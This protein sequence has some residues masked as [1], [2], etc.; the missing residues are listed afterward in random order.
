[1][2][3]RRDAPFPTLM[4]T[5]LRLP[6]RCL[7]GSLFPNHPRLNPPT[8]IV[9]QKHLVQTGRQGPDVELHACYLLT[10]AV[11]AERSSRV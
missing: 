1:M 2:R 9:L 10:A 7:T 6:K 8:Y 3:Q 11:R 5:A 4:L